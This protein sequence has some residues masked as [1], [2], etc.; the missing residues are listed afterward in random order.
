MHPW[1]DMCPHVANHGFG[2]PT[3]RS[4]WYSTNQFTLELIFHARA[5]NHPCRTYD[6]KS[7]HFFYIPFYMGYYTSSS[8]HAANHTVRDAMALDLT[9]YLSNISSFHLHGGNDHFIVGGRVVYDF[10]RSNDPK[11]FS[12]NSHSTRLL[13]LPEFSNVSVLVIERGPWNLKDTNQFGIPYPSYFH[14][15]TRSEMTTW[16]D[17]VRRSERNHLFTF[18]GAERSG[19][20]TTA[21]IRSELLRQCSSSERCLLINCK[22]NPRLCR[23][24]SDW[25]MAVMKRAHFCVQPQGDT[26]TRRS[27][28]DSVLAGCIP[29]FFSENTAYNQYPWYNPEKREDWSVLIAPEKVDQTERILA[30]IPMEEVERMREVVIGMIPHVMYVDPNATQIGF[31]DA[32]DVALI[33]MT[34]RVDRILN[35]S[36]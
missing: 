26:W 4:G 15:S 7:A 12:Y 8:F 17:E 30:K 19:N 13:S 11:H 3:S 9:N 14:P 22:V 34:K 32:V 5:S 1:T 27:M 28:F 36:V 29:V 18:I 16:Q 21:K 20:S 24:D 23:G 10:Y 33:E 2:Q 35:V 6:R 25:I 31:H